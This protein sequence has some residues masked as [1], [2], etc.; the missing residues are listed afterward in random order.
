MP[1]TGDSPQPLNM[2]TIML[3]A[4]QLSDAIATGRVI[5]LAKPLDPALGPLTLFPGT[6]E[7]SGDLAGHG[8]NMIALPYKL[9]GNV[10]NPN[11]PARRSDF[12]LLLNQ[13]N[14]TLTFTTVDKGVPNRGAAIAAVFD[15]DQHL[16]ALQY[17][18]HIEQIAAGDF[19]VTPNT[20]DTPKGP[21]AI[22]H[23]P[24]VFLHFFSET[25]GGPDI[26]RLGT[27]PHGDAVL[28]LGNGVVSDGPPDFVNVGDF[29]PLPSGVTPD[30]E[31]NPYLE[32]YKTF[33]LA[34][35]RGLF[36]PTNPLDLLKKAVA[37]KKIRRTT[38]ITLDTTLASGGI[39]NI[40]FVVKQADATSMRAI[41]WIEELD[42]GPGGKPETWL[43]YAQKV[44]LDF[45]LI[46]GKVGDPEVGR[47][48][49]PHISI[50]T[51][52]LKS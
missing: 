19:P 4:K 33:K 15:A 37:G 26:A 36:D 48:R 20:P 49:W 11:T 14:E 47:I 52:R 50:N 21:A 42:T 40:P 41:F 51:M 39:N 7:N 12:R 16:A 31:H 2:E 34:P 30:V 22:H 27:I 25:G 46:G 10:V 5:E 8:W 13:F 1:A 38:T 32:P 18:Q 35:F 29:L 23:E 43:Q 6:W 3:E 17:L 24:R 44:M 45:F 28:A 9:P